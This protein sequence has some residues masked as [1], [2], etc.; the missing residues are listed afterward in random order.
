MSKRVLL[1]DDDPLIQRLYGH[2]LSSASIE[3]MLASGGRE[4]LK[5]LETEN[6]DAIV[7]DIIMDDQDGLTTLREIKKRESLK[8]IPV[9]IITSN[10]QAN[11][12][13]QQEARAAGAAA[14]L[15]K[16]FSPNL[17][18]SEVERL[19]SPAR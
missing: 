18:V 8:N 2:F 6:P 5:L 12:L 17:L 10:I 11:S 13:F 15:T 14:F 9:I 3:V 7:M 4:A 16:P 1:V 19:T